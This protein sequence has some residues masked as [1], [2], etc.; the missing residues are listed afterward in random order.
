MNLLELQGIRRRY[1]S[2]TALDGVDLS[3]PADSCTAVVGPSGSGKTTL[4]RI[5]AGDLVPEAGSVARTGGLGV[6]RQFIGS[7]RDATTVQEFLVQ[8]APER[9]R[10]AWEGLEASEIV[11][12]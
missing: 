6:M 2:V 11:L 4:L 1:G 7:V 8:L 9:I 10:D 5:I 3:V 12:M